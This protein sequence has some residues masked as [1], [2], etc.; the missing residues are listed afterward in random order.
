M[1]A[2][3]LVQTSSTVINSNP[4]AAD[5]RLRSTSNSLPRHARGKSRPRPGADKKR[6]GKGKVAGQADS[7]SALRPA[8][9]FRHALPASSH[10][11]SEILASQRISVSEDG[12]LMHRAD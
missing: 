10:T 2:P 7:G 4:E 6:G 3:T 11:S 9:W 5:S 8:R 12:R 1:E